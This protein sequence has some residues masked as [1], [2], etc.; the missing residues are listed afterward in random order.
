MKTMECRNKWPKFMARR[1]TL[2]LFYYMRKETPPQ[3]KLHP[4]TCHWYRQ[5]KSI[6]KSLIHHTFQKRFVHFYY[7]PLFFFALL[8][9]LYLLHINQPISKRKKNVQLIPK[10]LPSSW[11]N[12]LS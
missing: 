1:S 5:I 12:L 6:Y 8:N 3:S 2:I 11:M 7:L 9:Y 4:R 10:V